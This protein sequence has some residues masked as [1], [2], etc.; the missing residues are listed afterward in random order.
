MPQNEILGSFKN[1]YEYQYFQHYIQDGLTWPGGWVRNNNGAVI[2]YLSD[3][4]TYYIGRGEKTNPY[5]NE[6]YTNMKNNHFWTGGW[7]QI[8]PMDLGYIT[9][10]ETPYYEEG[11]ELGSEDNPCSPSLFNDMSN[12]GL[13]NGGWVD[14]GN[15]YTYY[16]SDIDISNST[17][18]SGC[19]CGCGCGSGSGSSSGSGS[20]SGSGSNSG[21]GSESGFGGTR[22]S[23]GSGIAATFGC[24]G[25]KIIVS[26]TDGYVTHFPFSTLSIQINIDDMPSWSLL[27]NALTA[28]WAGACGVSIGGSF[29]LSYDNGNSVDTYTI[30]VGLGQYTVPPNYFSES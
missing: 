20:G 8:S 26:W 6:Y 21:S 29:T 18:S 19:G 1:P 14:Y 11:G 30:Y 9:M 16:V 5:P 2:Y 3:E 12:N 28:S 27:S 17:G 13:W 4:T 15:G 25:G 10:N 22:V 7:V 23:S 24:G